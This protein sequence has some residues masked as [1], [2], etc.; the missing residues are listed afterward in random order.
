MFRY[1]LYVY[2]HVP[3]RPFGSPVPT[4]PCVYLEWLPALIVLPEPQVSLREAAYNYF[5][6]LVIMTCNHDIAYLVRN[7]CNANARVQSGDAPGPARAPATWLLQY[8]T[9]TCTPRN[10]IIT[11]STT[12]TINT[13]RT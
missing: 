1:T 2:L 10:T 9:N 7:A 12:N 11:Y 8:A 13:F 4:P 3:W 5:Y 6:E